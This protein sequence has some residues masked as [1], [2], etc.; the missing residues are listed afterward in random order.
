MTT[1][2]EI[3]DE[4]RKV[5]ENPDEG[6][7][8]EEASPEIP[9]AELDPIA[10]L[11]AERDSARVEAA[12]N[13]ERFVRARAELDNVQ[14]RQQRELADRSRYGVEPLAR[15]LLGALD[16]LERALEHANDSGPF[17]QGVELVSKNILAALETNGIKRLDCVGK[18][19]DP[20]IHEAVTM[21]PA[22]GLEPGTVAAEHRGGYML[23]DRL[24][25]AA[26]VAVT[27]S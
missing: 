18:P 1:N 15:D 16:D 6:V 20:T 3:E 5:G 12:A 21:V 23:Q 4:E 7:A 10:A 17:V 25:R 22:N 2:Q 26:L 27:Q 8:D 13:F 11:E 14:K 24:L 19:F 9:G